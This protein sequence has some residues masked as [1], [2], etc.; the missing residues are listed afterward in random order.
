MT[1]QTTTTPRTRPGS[2]RPARD[3]GLLLQLLGR[4]YPDAEAWWVVVVAHSFARPVHATRAPLAVEVSRMQRI[5]DHKAL[6]WAPPGQFHAELRHPDPWRVDILPD[7]AGRQ[8]T[9]DRPAV[10]LWHPTYCPGGVLL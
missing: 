6:R 1:E 4:S 8:D 7:D 10:I 3:V 9:T 5:L 2:S